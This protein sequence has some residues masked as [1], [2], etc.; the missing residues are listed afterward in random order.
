MFGFGGKSTPEPA[1]EPA[2]SVDLGSESSFSH[3]TSSSNFMESSSS[4]SEDAELQRHLMREQQRAQFQ[5][6]INKFN[7]I[8][9]ETCIDK[10]SS[11]LDSKTET[12]I[13]N[14]V[15][16]FIDLNLFCAQKFAQ[17]IQQNGGF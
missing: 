1:P 12:C 9:W 15:N 6:Q 8:C 3:S 17:M 14:C 16:R 10:P 4:A 5:E 13:V 7:D 11:R 2:Y